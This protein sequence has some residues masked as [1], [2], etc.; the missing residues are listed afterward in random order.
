MI[1]K[2]NIIK[3]RYKIIVEYF[4]QEKL[5]KIKIESIIQDISEHTGYSTNCIYKIIKKYGK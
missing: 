5:K 3:T 2:L 4:N 1:D